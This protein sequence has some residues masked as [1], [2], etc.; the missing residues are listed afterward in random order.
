MTLAWGLAGASLVDIPDFREQWRELFVLQAQGKDLLRVHTAEGA[1]AHQL[2]QHAWEHQ[3][4][5]QGGQDKTGHGQP[6][7]GCT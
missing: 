7:E 2:H 1:Q 6:N 3:V 4:I 5:L